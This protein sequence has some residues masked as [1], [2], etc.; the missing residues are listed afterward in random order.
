MFMHVT[1]ILKPRFLRKVFSDREAF[2]VFLKNLLKW[3]ND[4]SNFFYPCNLMS[5]DNGLSGI[6]LFFFLG[7]EVN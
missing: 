5:D 1:M 4:G 6:L 7:K 3:N 2:N